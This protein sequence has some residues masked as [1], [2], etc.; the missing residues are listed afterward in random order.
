M[1]VV[2]FIATGCAIV[3]IFWIWLA[4][5]VSI[6]VSSGAPGAVVFLV[7]T[8]FLAGLVATQIWG[9]KP[10]AIA[11]AAAVPAG[12]NA[13]LRPLGWIDAKVLRLANESAAGSRA[14]SA[15]VRTDATTFWMAS[16]KSMPTLAPGAAADIGGFVVVHQP[17][18]GPPRV[19]G[20]YPMANV[21]WENPDGTTGHSGWQPIPAVSC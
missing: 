14:T 3:I 10:P 11:P 1:R 6:S 20:D 18:A 15:E 12:H 8:G 4:T 7:V 13:L 2:N 19:A 21:S 5:L 9:K 16:G 17:T